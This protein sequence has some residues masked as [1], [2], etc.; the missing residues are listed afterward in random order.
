MRGRA[1]LWIWAKPQLDRTSLKLAVI[2]AAH[3]HIYGTGGSVWDLV[4]KI[5]PIKNVEER[6]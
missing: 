4:E 3:G 5:D 6:P 2:V 1:S